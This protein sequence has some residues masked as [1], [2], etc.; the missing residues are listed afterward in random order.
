[1]KHTI[2]I[3][4]ESIE[5]MGDVRQQVVKAFACKRTA[6]KFIEHQNFKL[7]E[8]KKKFEDFNPENLSAIHNKTTL[9][10]L[11]RF[12]KIYSRNEYFVK[13]VDLYA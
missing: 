12:V 13:E 8:L 1:M 11:R 6:R 5:V 2:Y 3:V 7:A 4:H 9:A 10:K